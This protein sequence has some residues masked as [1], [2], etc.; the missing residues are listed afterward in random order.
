MITCVISDEEAETILQYDEDH[1]RDLKSKDIAPAKLSQSISAFAN[2]AGGELFVGV[3]KVG[4]RREWEGFENPESANGVFQVLE[5]LAPLGNLYSA[6]F[7]TCSA[8]N[9]LVLHLIIRKT[10]EI[11]TAT[12]GTAYVRRSAQKLPVSEEEAVRRL[13][14][15]KGYPRLRMRRSTSLLRRSQIL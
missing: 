7:L 13:R 3:S 5:G 6:Q 2:T 10:R 1:F 9:G 15:D 14:L 8:G 4:G 12:N 11:V